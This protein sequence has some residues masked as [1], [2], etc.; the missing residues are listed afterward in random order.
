VILR[1]QGAKHQYLRCFF[2]PRVLKKSESTTYLTI[3][4]NFQTKKKTAGVT[5]TTTT[6][7]TP[8]NNNNNT[9]AAAAATTTTTKQAGDIPTTATLRASAVCESPARAARRQ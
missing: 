8:T 9:T 2:A 7:T 4:G 1:F 5:T 6:T 3:F